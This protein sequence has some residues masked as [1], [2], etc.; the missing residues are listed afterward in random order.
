MAQD[1]G[2]RRAQIVRRRVEYV[3]PHAHRRFGE[4][5]CI[6]RRLGLLT[7]IQQRPAHLVLLLKNHRA[8]LGV[9]ASR[10]RAEQ[11]NHAGI[12]RLYSSRRQPLQ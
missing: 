8:S 1:D 4:P 9:E 5:A 10:Q 6:L 11:G 3:C 2:D 7:R 12:Q